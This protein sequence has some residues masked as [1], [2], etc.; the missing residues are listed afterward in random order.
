MDFHQPAVCFDCGLSDLVVFSIHKL[1]SKV[2]IH[3]IICVKRKSWFSIPRVFSSSLQ[4]VDITSVS[5]AVS[6]AS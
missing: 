6:D 5:S 1:P 2:T 4:A 3:P